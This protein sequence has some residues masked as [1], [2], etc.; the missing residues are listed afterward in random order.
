MIK[1]SVHIFTR[2]ER[3]WHWS[4]MSL[5]MILLFTGFRIHG[6]YELID[7]ETAVMVHTYAALSL[8][9]IWAF[10]IFWLFTTGAW[11]HYLPTRKGLLKVAK[12][13][14]FGIFKGE[15]HPYKKTYTRK[16]NP[17]Q[18]ISYLVLKIMIF[19]AIWITGLAYLTYG[20]WNTSGIPLEW[21]AV[22]H[23]ISAFAISVF[24]IAHVYLLST[25]HSFKD[26]VKPMITGFDEVYLTEEEVAYL[27]TNEPQNIKPEE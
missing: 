16:H 1:R 14:A 5:I 25:G 8:L 13:Y 2:F 11:K 21:V 15:R 24:I 22:L 6:F 20:F 26:H 19:P 18:A 7:F 9:L 17:L 10:A 27:E 12:Y 23:T 3:L 4:Q